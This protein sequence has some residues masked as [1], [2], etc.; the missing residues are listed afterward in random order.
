MQWALAL[1]AEARD[2]GLLTS[3]MAMVDVTKKVDPPVRKI[4]IV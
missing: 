2:E 3:D 1:L 4:N